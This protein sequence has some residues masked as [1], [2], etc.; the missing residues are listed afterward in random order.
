MLREGEEGACCYPAQGADGVD[1]LPVLGRLA[2]GAGG[3]ALLRWGAG[4]RV[5]HGGA[6]PRPG[7]VAPVPAPSDRSLCFAAVSV[8]RFHR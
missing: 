8:C 7:G 3:R 4:A 5:R 2:L 1:A 6:P